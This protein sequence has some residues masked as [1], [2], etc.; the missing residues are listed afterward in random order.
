MCLPGPPEEAKGTKF[1]AVPAVV[2]RC[3]CF[4]HKLTV[5][6]GLPCTVSATTY[7]FPPD[8]NP[9]LDNT[10]LAAKPGI[11]SCFLCTKAGFGVHAAVRFSKE[12]EAAMVHTVGDF[13]AHKFPDARLNV[14]ATEKLARCLN[15]G[16]DTPVNLHAASGTPGGCDMMLHESPALRDLRVTFH[17]PVFV[18]CGTLPSRDRRAC[19]RVC[20]PASHVAIHASTTLAMRWPLSS[21]ADDLPPHVCGLSPLRVVNDPTGHVPARL[22]PCHFRGSVV[23]T[24]APTGRILHPCR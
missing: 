14:D 20:H 23:A 2:P 12:L 4:L 6:W 13:V 8:L 16:V 3:G 11:K 7:L 9:D 10:E 21:L 1:Q 15:L 17:V 19:T 5:P 24:M 22:S 18:A